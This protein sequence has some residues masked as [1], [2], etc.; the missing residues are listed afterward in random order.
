MMR[1]VGLLLFIGL[2]AACRHA[3][4]PASSEPRLVRSPG[5]LLLA[6]ADPQALLVLFP[7]FGGD[8]LETREESK[9]PDEAVTRHVAVLLMDFSHRLFVKEAEADRLLDVIDSVVVSERI[10]GGHVVLGGWSAGGNVSVALAKRLHDAPRPHLHVDGLFVVDSPLDLTQL[11]PIWKRHAEHSPY[12]SAQGEGALVIDLLDRTL[13]PWPDSAANYARYSPVT[14]D[15][16]S[17]APL[18]KLAV[19]LYTEPDTAWWRINRGDAYEDMNACYLEK[20]EAELRS[21][22]C[23]RAAYIT[24]QGRGY[25]HGRRH[26]HAWSIVEEKELVT[27]VLSLR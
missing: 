5:L 9:I 17:V 2:L 14:P 21:A 15:T 26:P 24:T 23:S 13:G 8:A 12:P 25:Q 10:E 1:T 11:Y 22:G 20:L 19:R 3:T 16:A 6:P 4:A 18:K 7:G 27:W